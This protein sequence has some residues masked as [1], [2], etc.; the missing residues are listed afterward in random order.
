MEGR[1]FLFGV[2]GL[3][4][5]DHMKSPRIV[6]ACH[7]RRVTSVLSEKKRCLICVKLVSNLP[8]LP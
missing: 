2:S 1:A 8:M 7:L 5:L 4:L 6:Y 3:L